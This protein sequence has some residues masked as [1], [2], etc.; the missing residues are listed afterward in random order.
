MEG[1]DLTVN[2]PLGEGTVKTTSGLGGWSTLERKRRVAMS[3]YNGVD[4]IKFDVPLLLDGWSDRVNIKPTL[5]QLIAFARDTSQFDSEPPQFRIWG[6]IVWSGRLVVMENLE[7]G[8]DLWENGT[9]YR[10]ALVA[11]VAEYVPGDVLAF[12]A[13]SSGGKGKKKKKKKHVV[14]R[15]ETLY[16]IAVDVYKDKSK[17]KDIAK[18]NGI[19][20]PKKLKVGSTLN[21]P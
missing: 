7:F 4:P 6:P 12:E 2:V 16:S 19:R 9:L 3:N 17:W 10:Q 13:P 18:L 20:D 1:A 11:H 15:G 8:D 21:L 14:K 5:D